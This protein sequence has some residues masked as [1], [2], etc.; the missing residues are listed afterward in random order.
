MIERPLHFISMV[1]SNFLRPAVDR[2]RYSLLHVN[3]RQPSFFYH[4]A[5]EI[6]PSSR[7]LQGSFKLKRCHLASDISMCSPG[8]FL[9]TC[10]TLVMHAGLLEDPGPIQEFG[11]DL[12]TS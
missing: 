6:S 11:D 7:P 9:V 5:L 2:L 8:K 10:R 12:N 1:F 3:L 4:K